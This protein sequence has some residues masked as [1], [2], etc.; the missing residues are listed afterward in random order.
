MLCQ[1]S[2][3]MEVFVNAHPQG[4]QQKCFYR[5]RCVSVFLIERKLSNYSIFLV[6]TEPIIDSICLIY[7]FD[8]EGNIFHFLIMDK[9]NLSPVGDMG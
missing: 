3:S 6:I 1:T 9:N 7:Q 5:L 4:R 8:F 2:T